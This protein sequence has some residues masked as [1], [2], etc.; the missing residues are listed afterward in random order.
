VR[1]WYDAGASGWR[2]DV[3]N[4]LGHDW[5]KDFRPY[6]KAYKPDG[7]LVGEIWPNAAQ[8]LAGDQLDSVMNYRFRKNVL[9]FVR[10]A[11]YS[12]TNNNGTNRIVGLKP[13]QFDHALRAVLEDYPP[14][15]SA[16]M[17]NLLDSHDT[18][19]A[20]YVLT[21][22]GDTGLVQA[23]ERLKLAALF[24]FTYLGAPMVYYGDEAGMNAPSLASDS[25]GALG[26]P[27]NRAPYPWL[28]ESGDPSIYG[29][30][31]RS[32][33]GYYTRL[34]HVR[35]HHRALRTGSVQTLLTGDTMQSST[36]ANTYAFA[37]V[38][39][40]ETAIVALNNGNLANSASIPVAGLLVDGTTVTDA[41]SGKQYTVSN[42]AI[43]VALP[44]RSG[45][46]LLSKA[47]KSDEGPDEED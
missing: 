23:K 7:P 26:D 14:Q 28:D 32:L 8:W 9:G 30:P 40:G 21:E 37:R 5:W 10:N 31:D 29:P 45:A 34:A 35:K 20:L 19:R 41:L 38:G 42:G 12:D 27:Y 17:L 47:T 18:N 33:I 11:D 36:A 2:F 44:A 46:L 22:A 13:S 3:A 16:T 6:A 4:E 1:H 25:T 43:A 24:Q 39:S 15:A